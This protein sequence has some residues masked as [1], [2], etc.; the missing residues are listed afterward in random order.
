[1]SLRSNLS[2]PAGLVLTLGLLWLGA[3]QPALARWSHFAPVQAPMTRSLRL[4]FLDPEGLVTPGSALLYLELDGRSVGT[5]AASELGAGRVVFEVPANLLEGQELT[6][7]AEIR[8]GEENTQLPGSGQW[9]VTLAPESELALVNLLSDLDVPPGEETLLAFSAADESVDL[10]ASTLWIDGQPAPGDLEADP[11]LVTWRGQL[12]AGPHAVELRLKD[13][14]GRE[15][16]PQRLNLTVLGAESVAMGYEAS[17]WE[18][19][20]MD[21]L[22]SRGAGQWQRY[23]AGQLRFRAW[24]GRGEEAW[25]LKGRVLLSGQDLESDE[26]QPQ[27]RLNLDLTHKGLLLGVGDRQ[28]EYSPLLLS[29]TRVRGG[30]LGL[31]FRQFGLRVVGGRAREARDPLFGA[32]GTVEF[33]GSFARNLY[34]LD[35]RMGRRGGLLEGG[36]TLLKVKDDEASIRATPP[37]SWGSD[38]LARVSPEDNLGLGARLDFNAFRGHFS[39]RNQVAFALHNTDISS[40]SWTKDDLE[41]LGA[42]DLPDPSSFE[43]LIVI[44]QYFSPLDLADGDVLTATAL[45][46]NWQWNAGPNDLLLDFRRIGGAYRSLGNSFLTPDQQELRVTERVRLL[47]N[48]LYVDLGGGL[49]SDNLDGQYDETVGTT[50]RSLFNLGLGWYPRGRDLQLRLGFEQQQ[51]A[52][53]ALEILADDADP[54]SELNAA[55]QHIEGGL[56]QIR[57]GLSGSLDWLNR[58]HQWSLSLLNQGYGDDVGQVRDTLNAVLRLDRSYSSNQL[59]LG[60][61]VNLDPRWRLDAGFSIYGS[62]YDDRGM[63]DYSYWN[64]RGALGRDWLAGRLKSALRAQFQDVSSETGGVSGAFTRLDLGGELDW[65]LRQ[66]LGLAGRVDWQSWAGDREDSFLKVVLRLSQD[67]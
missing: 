49:T 64:L 41:T 62:D 63:T 16:Q 31:E 33:A 52:N 8:S 5:L 32:P 50:A 11:W 22:D 51:E 1:M 48:Q 46:S 56:Q 12:P 47:Q 61:Q 37:S 7:R 45:T 25:N 2:R 67:F 20:N 35:L 39:G 28:P 40:G 42:G 38:S 21:F 14:Q 59:G 17:A 15:L 53:E 57:L 13:R 24:R 27:S 6:Y 10:A 18:E 44:N 9:R 29:G 36:L 60:W 23:H 19:F 4:E 65:T 54:A 26:L 43:D 55:S 34:S 66:G 58:R 30:E 3:A